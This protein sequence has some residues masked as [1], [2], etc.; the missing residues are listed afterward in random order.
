MKTYNQFLT[1]Q[2]QVELTAQ[3]L[4]KLGINMGS[5]SSCIEYAYKDSDEIVKAIH[6]DDPFKAGLTL[7][8]SLALSVAVTEEEKN[9]HV[10]ESELDFLNTFFKEDLSKNEKVTRE[11]ITKMREAYI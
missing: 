6:K 4:L 2:T 5:S 7:V 9:N 10:D 1:T 11:L 3:R 8:K